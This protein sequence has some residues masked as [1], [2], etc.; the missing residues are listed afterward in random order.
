MGIVRSQKARGWDPILLTTPRY[1]PSPADHETIDDQIFH[2]SK[3][4]H[5]SAPALRELAEMQETKRRLAEIIRTEQPD[6]LHAHSPVLNALPAISAGRRFGLP[7][8][9]EVRAFW[10]DAA[11][12]HGTARGGGPRYRISRL[13]ETYALKRV[14]RV[15]A[16]CEP[17]RAEIMARGISSERVS[18]VP[19]A[20]DPAF[21]VLPSVENYCVRE[22]LGISS[23]TVVLGFIGSFYAYEGLDLLLEA[24]PVLIQRIP[25]LLVL[26]VGGGPDEERLRRIVRELSI[27]RFVRFTGRV[28]HQEVASYCSVVDVFVFPRRRIRLTDLVTPLKPLEAMAQSKPVIAS[29]VGGHCELIRDSDTGYLFAADDANALAAKVEAVIANVA[30]RARVALNGRKFVEK[31]RTWDVVVQRY[32]SVYSQLLRGKMSTQ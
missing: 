3:Q 13:L 15:I 26:L 20:V 14:E 21:L 32:A 2:R 30:D 29:N 7:V 9:Y 5:V 8:V 31:E 1:Q 16:L 17:L 19:N 11:V 12:D 22:R 18:I 23:Q 27:E 25:Q 4:V 6:I 24:V 28:H 10:E